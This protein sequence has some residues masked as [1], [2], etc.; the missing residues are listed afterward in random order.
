MQ[1]CLLACVA[2]LQKSREL[3]PAIP[4]G[5]CHPGVEI[6]SHG[7][8]E[9]SHNITMVRGPQ[10]ATVRPWGKT[11]NKAGKPRARV[12]AAALSEGQVLSPA[13]R[14]A[15]GSPTGHR[16]ARPRPP[17]AES[18]AALRPACVRGTRSCFL[19][20]AQCPSQPFFSVSFSSSFTLLVRRLETR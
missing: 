12:P 11:G 20:V 2:K 7:K 17:L 3:D 15:G 10:R 9:K 5:L 16:G 4:E 13:P 1:I 8:G 19:T 6:G 18:R 14:S